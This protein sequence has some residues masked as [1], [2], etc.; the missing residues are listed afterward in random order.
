MA[1]GA[2]NWAKEL[3]RP[4]DWRDQRTARSTGDTAP[5]SDGRYMAEL[6]PLMHFTSKGSNGSAS[7]VGVRGLQRGIATFVVGP[8]SANSGRWP[9]IRLRH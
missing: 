8:G 5:G 6:R 2:G 1:C 4:T 7:D 9:A 3:A